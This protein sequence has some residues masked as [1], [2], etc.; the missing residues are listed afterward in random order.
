MRL[1]ATPQERRVSI[2]KKWLNFPLDGDSDYHV[3]TRADGRM[4]CALYWSGVM[5]ELPDM[6]EQIKAHAVRTLADDHRG[7]MA[8]S[9]GRILEDKPWSVLTAQFFHIANAGDEYRV[10]GQPYF[11][12]N[13]AKYPQSKPL[14]QI[15]LA[16]PHGN[17]E[18]LIDPRLAGIAISEST[19][20]TDLEF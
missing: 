8:G 13:S 10:Y 12:I 4:L 18:D 19:K 20:I 2:L 16:R 6:A 3:I 1:T 11:A 5:A 15:A 7:V 14:G 9:E 17:I